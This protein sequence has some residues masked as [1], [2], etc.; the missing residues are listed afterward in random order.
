MKVFIKDV[1]R[2]IELFFFVA[3]GLYLV[4]NF[5]ERFYGTYGIT[6][7]GN[8]WVNWFG[9]S[10]FLFVL[11]ALLMGLVFFKNVKFYNDFLTS[12]MSWALL[13]VS[14]FILVIPFIKG[15]NPF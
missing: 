4:Y 11:Y 8:I 2:S 12:K 5:G 3:I 13:G 14:I 15:E 1:G 10:Y 9:L 6:F 7:T